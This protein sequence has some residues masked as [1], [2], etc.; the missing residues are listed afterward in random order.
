MQSGQQHTVETRLKQSAA[1]SRRWARRRGSS[2]V[3]TLHRVASRHGEDIEASSASPASAEDG[4]L[5]SFPRA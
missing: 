2:A 1:A 5:T 4:A 3:A